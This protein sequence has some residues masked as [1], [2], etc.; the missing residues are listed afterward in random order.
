VFRN[1]RRATPFGPAAARAALQA[2]PR[3]TAINSMRF[4][5]ANCRQSHALNSGSGL[6][7]V[8]AYTPPI[9]DR[10]HV[11]HLVQRGAYE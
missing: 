5:V 4:E 9:I 7:E 8:M 2:I 11:R 6:G 1:P 10:P 3:S